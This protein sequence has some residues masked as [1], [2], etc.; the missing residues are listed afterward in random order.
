MSGLRKLRETSF[1]VLIIKFARL[2]VTNKLSKVPHPPIFV[3]VTGG[4]PNLKISDDEIELDAA[5]EDDYMAPDDLRRGD[6][7]KLTDWR[8]LVEYDQTTKKIFYKVII[9]NSEKIA[10]ESVSD[11]LKSPEDVAELSGAYTILH[12][13]YEASMFD[14]THDPDASVRQIKD[15]LCQTN[16]TP[17][18]A[19]TPS[20]RET[21]STSVRKS[22]VNQ[23]VD[24]EDKLPS[25]A[26]KSAQKRNYEEY[27]A[28]TPTDKGALLPIKLGKPNERSTTPGKTSKGRVQFASPL[29]EKQGAEE[30]R[31]QQKSAENRAIVRHLM[32]NEKERKATPER[33]NDMSEEAGDKGKRSAS[34]GSKEKTPGKVTPE[35]MKAFLMLMKEKDLERIMLPAKKQS[36]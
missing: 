14:N 32:S 27:S 35:D 24:E 9:E 22:R 2:I 31:S 10:W 4:N 34:K 21:G 16:K 11:H 36:A 18:K 30:K 29:E 25:T 33:E 23:A 8:L 6:I 5:F 12:R 26:K 19:A 1:K 20:K 3:Q 17:R 28:K 7:L 15:V 13:F